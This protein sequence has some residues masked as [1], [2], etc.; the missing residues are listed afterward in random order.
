VVGVAPAIRDERLDA[1]PRPRLYVG[2][3][4]FPWP[5]VS[6]VLRTAGDP[7]TAVAAFRGALPEVRP[8]L[9]LGPTAELSQVLAGVRAW[10]RSGMQV[11]AFFGLAALMLAAVGVYGAIASSVESRTREI[12]VRLALGA[13]PRGV[14]LL[15]LGCGVSLALIG[16]GGGLV[17]AL[18]VSRL[19]QGFLYG[20]TATDAT[21]FAAVAAVILGAAGVAAGIPASRAARVDPTRALRAD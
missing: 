21:S 2:Y 12:G 4:F 6:I 1:E 16:L 3:D 8:G 18:A 14:A 17:A 9:A 19:I 7:G 11:L 5:D 10:P 20:V 13:T 15:L